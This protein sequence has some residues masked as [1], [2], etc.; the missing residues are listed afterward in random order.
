MHLPG[1]AQEREEG[2]PGLGGP[3]EE[4][5]TVPIRGQMAK[6]AAESAAGMG[7]G[8]SSFGRFLKAPR[9]EVL[10]VSYLCSEQLKS[11][12][13]SSV[14]WGHLSSACHRA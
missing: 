7:V 14:P 12:I 11:S 9:A 2:E 10:K 4:P 5:R 13:Y 1:L 6:L 8:G 3:H